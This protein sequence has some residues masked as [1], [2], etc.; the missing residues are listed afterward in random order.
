[1]K[2]AET[3]PPQHPGKH[4]RKLLAD[5]GISQSDLAFVLGQSVRNVNMIVQEKRGISPEMSK[6]LGTALDRSPN[7]FADLQQEYDLACADDPHP[8]ISLRNDMIK[9]YPVREMIRRQWIQ[10]GDAEAL[11]SQLVAY[12]GVSTPEELPHLTHAAKKT[13][14]D[15]DT[16]EYNLLTWLFRVKK[17]ASASVVQP[18]S[19]SGLKDAVKS[20][21]EMLAKPEE[22]RHVP[23]MLTECGVRFVIVESLPKARIDGVCFWLNEDSPVI[24]MSLRYDRID[25]F[26]FVLR[27]EIEHVLR[28]H[29]QDNPAID[30]DLEGDKAGTND[31]IP[32]QE[33]VANAAA[34][35]FCVP[36]AKLE[37]FV[38]RKKPFYYERDVVAFAQLQGVHPGLVV[39]QLQ[40]RLN[41][42]NYLNKYQVKVR[43]IVVPNAMADGWG[44]NVPV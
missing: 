10:D 40:R 6:A 37:S 9:S 31:S 11:Q 34:A 42:Y 19:P 23:R 29:G 30:S 39:G 4:L 14:Y 2:E 7:F 41:R 35:D 36:S 21:R 5:R 3:Q 33:R 43:Q 18:Y 38:V 44:Q 28:K 26:W 24:G 32:E 16:T 13:Y 15:D 8:D 17:I 22:M 27:H 1:M 25:N 20:F 12:F